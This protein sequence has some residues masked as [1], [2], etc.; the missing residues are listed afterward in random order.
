M[1][2]KSPEHQQQTA[3]FNWAA[4]YAELRTMYAIPNGEMRSTLVA[5]RLKMEGV[6]AGIPDICLP[7]ARGKYHALY[8]EMKAPGGRVATHQE[9]MHELL[10]RADNLVVVCR[11]T[12]EAIET[13]CRYMGMR[14]PFEYRHAQVMGTGEDGEGDAA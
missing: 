8:I 11:S 4:H 9:L 2:K 5:K 3:V 13:I 14:S 1:P 12:P 10:S 6:R 7:V